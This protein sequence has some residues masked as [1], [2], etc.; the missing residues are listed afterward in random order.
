[1]NELLQTRM[2]ELRDLAGVIGLSTWDQETYLPKKA[3]AAR[4]SQLSTLQGLY[5]QQLVDPRLGDWLADSR[6]TDDDQR[7]MVFL[8]QRERDRAVKL[9]ERLVRALAEAQSHAL[10]AWREARAAR[11]YALFAPHL[12]T[13]LALRREQ[14]DAWGH[15]GERYDALLEAY[16]PGMRVSRL[17]P[18][19][20]ALAAKVTPLVDQLTALA[21]LPRV[22]AGL[23]FDHDA[24]W[25]FTLQLLPAMG[26][27]LAAGRQDQSVH[28]FSCGLHP[29]DV[30]LTTRLSPASPFSAITGTMHEGGH[31]LY[32][33]G[34]DPAHAR[35]TLAQAP[36]MGLHESQSRLWENLV[37]RSAAFWTHFFPRLRREFPVQLGGVSFDRFLRELNRVEKS[38]I[39]VDADEVTYDLHIVLRTELE[40]ELLRGTLGPNELEEAWNAKTRQLLGL[41]VASPEQGVLQDIHWAW[42]E[43]GYF[44]T[45]TLGTLYAASLWRALRA[46]V[47]LVEAHL[48]GGDLTP[49]TG[50]L[51]QHVHREGWRFD[52]EVLVQRLTGRGLTDEDYVAGLREKYGALYALAR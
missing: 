23:T 47:P 44:P 21:P 48:A 50:W 15:D 41:T 35:T 45:Y 43:F 19:L 28:P 11:S 26:F 30:R 2:N 40:L 24:Q 17:M 10:A 12:A 13:L 6:A 25:R 51:R 4:A 14:A 49:V 18:V 33:Q 3:E 42:G 46:A 39:R 29:T 1:M 8:L 20:K 16:E 36:S 7:R 5:H 31:G 37:G 34:F 52:A 22:L 27:D 38:F 9:P 32:E